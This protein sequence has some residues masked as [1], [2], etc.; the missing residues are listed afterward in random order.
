MHICIS[1]ESSKRK[2]F[3][4]CLLFYQKWCSNVVTTFPCFVITRWF[5]FTCIMQILRMLIHTEPF[6]CDSTSGTKKV[7]DEAVHKSCFHIFYL[8]MIL[9]KLIVP[10]LS[11]HDSDINECEES[12]HNCNVNAECVNLEGSF[13]CECDNGFEGNGIIC[14]GNDGINKSKYVWNNTR[15]SL[16]TF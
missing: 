3:L 16:L 7:W 5:F 11:F 4:C 6:K 1:F 10:F 2:Q 9:T 13:A 14:E 8:I 15:L 12:F